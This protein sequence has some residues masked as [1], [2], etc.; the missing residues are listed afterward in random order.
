M[1][2]VPM[3]RPTL[4]LPTFLSSLFAPLARNPRF[5]LTVVLIL[6]LGIGIN[7]ATLGLLYRYY[8]SPLPYPQ[9]G[10]ILSVYFT[11]NR[12]VLAAL[13][14]M[15]VPTWQRLQKGAPALVDSGLYA[16]RGYNLVRDGRLSR[17]NGTE[18]TASV[19]S[20]LGV[21]PVL[22]RVFGPQSN[23]P[24]AKPVVVLSYRLWQ[25]LFDGMASAIGETLHLNGKL[26][27]VIGVMPKGFNFPTAQSA[28]WT[29]QTLDDFDQNADML[30]AFGYHMVGR[31]AQGAS[32]N[33]FTTQ[34]NAVLEREIANFPDPSAIPIFKKSGYRIRATRWRASRLGNLHQSLVLVFCATALLMLLVWFNLANLI[35]ARGF[36]RRAELA[37][38][39]ILGA[40]TGALALSLA[41]E[42][43]IL[44]L[45]G[46]GL[47]VVFGR[48]LLD[49]FSGSS[50]AVAA[51]S[52]SAASW[53]ALIVIAL[54]LALISAGIFTLTNV[55]F[56][57]G[58]SLS[59]AL[60]DASAHAS[61]GRSTKRIRT[62]LIA[63]QIALAC[64]IAGTG[65]LLGRGL[66]NLN[67]VNLGFK[68]DHVVTFK[69]SFPEAQYSLKKM[70]AAL[71]TLRGSVGRLP[72]MS[73]VSVSSA[74]PFNGDMAGGGVYPRPP[75]P[76]FKSNA[77][78]TATDADY[79]R[80]FGMPLLAGR[81]FTPADDN[82]GVSLA[83]IDTLAAKKLFGTENAVGREFSFDGPHKNRFGILFRVIGVVPT[84]HRGHVGSAPAMGSVYID[85]AQVVGKY[86]NWSW[87]F[88]DWYLSVRSPLSAASVISEVKNAAHKLLP[89]IPL[90]DVQTMNQRLGDALA[91]NRLLSLL[92]GLFAFGALLLAAIGL[93][94]VQAYAVAQRAREFAIRIALGAER[95][96]LLAMVV[97]EAAR[98]LVIGLV[99]GLTGLAAIG[100]AFASAFYGISPFDP[101]SMIVVTAVL[102]LA[103]LAASWLPAWRA[104][105]TVP[106]TALRN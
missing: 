9:G 58:N 97:G 92:V 100:V 46:A 72:G 13:Q 54:I 34:A 20:T 94:A 14:R 79:F 53:P 42:N 57:R 56:L 75:N 49:L 1:P 15:S 26:Y 21:H 85:A 12:P 28:L 104:S 101:L 67:A 51:S 55:S 4:H 95:G 41:R 96:R 2:G 86:K 76:A 44:S 71:A 6:G 3:T 63:G 16:R 40:N 84:V 73:A 17:V 89:D 64:A 62:G 24:G 22:G 87:G 102:C 52:I 18:A 88:P 105:R 103:A 43:F 70:I 37:L 39:R 82:A 68:P 81:D 7:V 90:Y 8:V 31:L 48:F 106:S 74:V 35:L 83:I 27:S 91:P 65:L 66:L 98:L 50:V 19:F 29:P 47:G 78:P 10:R 60:G 38:R 80:T 61:P 45:I 59:A 77:F 5:A 11:A 23:K 32:V 33:S 25:T 30:T 36:S 69:L 93:Y 99:I